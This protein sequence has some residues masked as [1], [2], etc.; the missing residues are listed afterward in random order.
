MAASI[1]SARQNLLIRAFLAIVAKVGAFTKD[2]GADGAGYIQAAKNTGSDNG[3]R[4]ENCAFW[5]AGGKCSIVKGA[6]EQ[7]GICRLHVI[8]QSRLVASQPIAS[9]L[10][11]F[12]VEKIKG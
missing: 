6:I 3:F 4:C 2:A 11:R 8:P 12:R 5:R 10:G 9:G 7:Q 1:Y